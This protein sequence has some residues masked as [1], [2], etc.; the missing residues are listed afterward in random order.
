MVRLNPKPFTKLWEKQK[1]N[2]QNTNSDEFLLSINKNFSSVPSTMSPLH[3]T[4]RHPIQEFSQQQEHHT[5]S[6][7]SFVYKF[8]I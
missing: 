3:S 5:F 7:D 4:A 6:M 1:Q 8:C 2:K